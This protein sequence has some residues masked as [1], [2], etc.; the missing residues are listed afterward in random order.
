[1]SN[2]LSMDAYNR[3]YGGFCNDLTLGFGIG[4]ASLLLT[5]ARSLNFDDQTIGF[6]G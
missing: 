2:N 4:N 5:Q 6:M 3:G 1:M